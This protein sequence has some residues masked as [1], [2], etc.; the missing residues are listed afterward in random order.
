MF[1][2]NRSRFVLSIDRSN[3]HHI[4]LLEAQFEL[5]GGEAVASRL[6]EVCFVNRSIEVR[7]VNRSIEC[8]FNSL[9]RTQ[10]ELNGGEAV[11]SSVPAT[12]HSVM[13][14]WPNEAAAISNM[15][16]EFGT[17]LFSCVMDSYD[18]ADVSSPSYS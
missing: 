1:S 4:Y 12:E 6:I 18:Y 3:V 2:I 17:G 15:I 13:T 10:F 16:R 14:A 9:V 11:A 8:S 5:N 7:S